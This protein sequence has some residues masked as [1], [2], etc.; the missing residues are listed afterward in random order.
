MSSSEGEDGLAEGTA[1]GH[2]GEGGA[3]SSRGYVRPI[4]GSMTPLSSIGTRA[5]H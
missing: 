2:L 4:G 5:S 1:I 3:A